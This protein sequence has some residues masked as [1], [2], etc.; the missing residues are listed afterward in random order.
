MKFK[1]TKDQQRV[2]NDRGNSLL[3]AAAAGSGKTA[4]LVERILSL[5][6]DNLNPI[7]IDR[8]LIVTYTK[9][10]AFEMKEK[11]YNAIYSRIEE[12]EDKNLLL[13]LKKQIKLLPYAP[14]STIDSFCSK[15]LKENFNEV[16][17][18]PDFLVASEE[19]LKNLCEKV[20][21]EY[22]KELFEN[23]DEEFIKLCNVFVYR[24]SI[25]RLKSMVLTLYNQSQSFPW[26]KEWLIQQKQPYQIKCIQDILEADWYRDTVEIAKS[27]L[28]NVRDG[29]NKL[30]DF[31][32]C[33][34]DTEIPH[35][36]NSCIEN[37]L[38]EIE[39]ALE[40]FENRVSD[41]KLSTLSTKSHKGE[42]KEIR[43]EAKDKRDE[44]KGEIEDILGLIIPDKEEYLSQT[45]FM[46]PI[47]EKLIDIT[48][49]FSERLLSKKI[50]ENTFSF[51]DV[52]HFALEILR[53][54][55]THEVTDTAV[56]LREFYLQV[57]VDEYQDSN[58]LQEEILTALVKSGS[59]SNYFM[60][61]DVKQSIYRFRKARPSLF[62][63]KYNSFK[64]G[65]DN[66]MVIDLQR[67]FRSRNAVTDCV[68]NIF[69]NIMGRDIGGVEY[70]SNASLVFSASY[71]SDD[72]ISHIPELL[73]VS[74]DSPVFTDNHIDR[75]SAEAMLIG[76]RIRELMQEFMVTDKDGQR[77][78]KYSDIVILHRSA[79]KI[80][81][82]YIQILREQGI[83]VNATGIRGYFEKFEVEAIMDMLICLNNPIDDIALTSV[84]MNFYN[85]S[86][87][88]LTV[89]IDKDRSYARSFL[90]NGSSCGNEK[91]NS[92]YIQFNKLRNSVKGKRLYEIIQI[93]SSIGY[94]RDKIL[95]SLNRNAME[96]NI[97]KLVDL[98]ISFEK[99]HIVGGLYDFVKYIKELKEYDVNLGDSL[100]LDKEAVRIMTIHKSK[101]LEFPVC[102]LAGLSKRKSPNRGDFGMVISDS[103]GVGFD[104]IDRELS[105]KMP[106]KHKIILSYYENM[107]NV[108]EE[109]RLLYVALT[110]AKEKLILTG[111]EK[112]EDIKNRFNKP[113]KIS[114][115]STYRLKAKSYLDLIMPIFLKYNY[116][117][118][119][120]AGDTLQEAVVKKVDIRDKE[121]Y[122]R[123]IEDKQDNRF[124]ET[125]QENISFKYPI[126][127]GLKIKSKYSVSEIKRYNDIHADE[128]ELFAQDTQDRE[129]KSKIPEFIKDNSKVNLATQKGI[130]MHRF[131]ECVN[132]SEN[133][134]IEAE[135]DRMVRGGFLTDTEYKLIDI[136]KIKGF[137]E[138]D[139]AMDM[140]RA[141]K[142][143]LLFKE[144]TFVCEKKAI[145]LFPKEKFMPMEKEDTVLIQGV[146]DAYYIQGYTA[147]IVDY[148][149]DKVNNIKEFLR[150]YKKQLDM[151]SIALSNA[152]GIE[153]C[154]KIIY[155]F[156]LGRKIVI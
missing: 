27:R 12:A 135:L 146:I 26:S 50:E 125:V 94:F 114:Y 5:I 153:K 46:Q 7:D 6:C 62:T 19:E 41:I 86:N 10:A 48:I 81:D 111:Y 2:I 128:T 95:V 14:I 21:E 54:K 49:D 87:D 92:A 141:K 78:V 98:A 76:K 68:N 138:S 89:L 156:D 63:E 45:V 73:L 18:L 88:D 16:G 67:N 31:V 140:I 30:L 119:E 116:R 145:E 36:Y 57:M 23:E 118:E 60:V 137:F 66:A 40:D 132:F 105:V 154:E 3:V 107:D 90:E 70:D 103:Y 15:L 56:R 83:P 75:D 143:N 58:L 91:I 77:P 72:T 93:I 51:G 101:G 104:Y 136:N 42:N 29:Y 47:I 151:Y 59:E 99:T 37:D 123:K 131:M 113:L 109:Q 106:M 11:I 38:S 79:N 155:S 149:T 71:Y 80:C 84:L 148:K 97:E 33:N 130:A 147:F 55:N 112:G 53:D 127:A 1:P 129:F 24:N 96:T 44:L 69:T 117:V 150:K 100:N 4:V 52:E 121:I 22:F 74:H 133:I 35:P 8:F 126:T 28:L 32:R 120:I 139:L 17:I 34:L 134:D 110:R 124:I 82:K 13:H 115:T 144:K 43:Q 61:G 108:A 64:D 39:Y 85:L 142:N 102:I 65:A 9:A 20:L 152:I 122:L 25:D